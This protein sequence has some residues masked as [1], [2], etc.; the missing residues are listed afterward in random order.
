MRK[1]IFPGLKKQ[2]KPKMSYLSTFGTESC[3]G[4]NI[5]AL[6]D[7]ILSTSESAFLFYFACFPFETRSAAK[8]L[9]LQVSVK[10]NG[11]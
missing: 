11:V 1:A 6:S 4:V 7:D 3:I 2:H 10:A 5:F 8:I 9:I